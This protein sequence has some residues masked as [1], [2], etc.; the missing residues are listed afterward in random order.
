MWHKK[1]IDIPRNIWERKSS[2]GKGIWHLRAVA[3]PGVVGRG[4]KVLLG[5]KCEL[6]SGKREQ[7]PSV[8]S[9]RSIL[10]FPVG[11]D[12]DAEKMRVG[13]QGGGCVLIV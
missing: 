5:S 2:I 12:T 4:A 6:D 3:V 13:G 11:V 10:T 9:A 7:S 1:S 8:P